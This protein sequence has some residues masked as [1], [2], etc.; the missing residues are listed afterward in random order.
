MGGGGMIALLL[1][2]IGELIGLGSATT[3][4]IDAARDSL[5]KLPDAPPPL[6]GDALSYLEGA[7]DMEWRLQERERLRRSGE[8]LARKV[9]ADA[10]GEWIEHKSEPPPPIG[11]VERRRVNQGG[12][13]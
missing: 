6:G 11:H 5:P 8:E 10:D 9:A 7:N 2:G 13:S 4:L 3:R 12:T 1:R